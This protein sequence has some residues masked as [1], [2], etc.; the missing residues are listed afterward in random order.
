MKKPKLKV[1]LRDNV[2]KIRNLEEGG[3]SLE[4]YIPPMIKK[5]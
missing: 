4:Y 2:G 3:W 5:I 1:E